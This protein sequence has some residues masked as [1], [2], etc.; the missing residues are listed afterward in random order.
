LAVA[1][2]TSKPVIKKIKAA[3]PMKDLMGAYFKELDE[4]ARTKSHKVAW[5]TSVGPAELL[6]ALGFR[7]Y[8]PENHGAL[9]GTSRLSTEY[10]P[11][12][13]A[14]GYAPSICSYLTSDVGSWLKKSTP[15]TKAF[16]MASVPRPD[17]LVFNTNQCRDV[18]DWFNF[19]SR[20]YQ[21]PVVGIE[22]PRGVNEVGSAHLAGMTAQFRELV[23]RLEEVAGKKLDIDRLREVVASSYNC[24]VLW[25][26]VLRTSTHRPA[27]LTFFDGTDRKSVV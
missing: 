8:F 7:V 13:N 23:P 17:I 5:C 26:R 1:D 22:T 10:I 24:S 19:Y 14:I 15:L 2:A 27:P 4:A 20:E 11:A 18:Q 6:R 12:A 25:K 3:G 21:V 9:L 16:G